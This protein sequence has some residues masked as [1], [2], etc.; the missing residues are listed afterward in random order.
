MSKRRKIKLCSSNRLR[1]QHLSTKNLRLMPLRS[2][3]N[4]MRRS[5]D[6]SANQNV[7]FGH[8]SA[9]ESNLTR[10]M[11]TCTISVTPAQFLKRR[12][13]VLDRSL[14]LFPVLKALHKHS[15]SKLR[16]RLLRRPK[17]RR[18]GMRW[19]LIRNDRKCSNKSRSKS[20]L[21]RREWRFRM[22]C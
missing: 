4:S 18:V 2:C 6:Q 8:G 19:R 11:R 21:R 12:R 20:R 7:E 22:I 15:S 17:R 10:M 13:R 16:R 14:G 9:M 3:S 5:T 1:K